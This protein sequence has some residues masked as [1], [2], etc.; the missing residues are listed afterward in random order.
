MMLLKPTSLV[1][2][3][4]HWEGECVCRVLKVTQISEGGGGI[5]LG[6]APESLVCLR[7]HFAHFHSGESEEENKE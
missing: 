7:L 1:T 6:H 5:F 3:Y 4:I 2:R